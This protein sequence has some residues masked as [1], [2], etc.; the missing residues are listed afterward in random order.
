MRNSVLRNVLAHATCNV[1]IPDY[2]TLG[3]KKAE[4]GPGGG[5]EG[6]TREEG[7]VADFPF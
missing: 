5:G 7:L 3:I 4:G 2:I 6:V 1:T